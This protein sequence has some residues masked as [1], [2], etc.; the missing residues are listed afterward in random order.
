MQLLFYTYLNIYTYIITVNISTINICLQSIFY[1][2]RTI[3][4]IGKQNIIV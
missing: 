1:F 2:S 4:F 3:E